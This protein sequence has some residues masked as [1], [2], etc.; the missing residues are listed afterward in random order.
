MHAH[1]VEIIDAIYHRFNMLFAHQRKIARSTKNWQVQ[2][3]RRP[4]DASLILKASISPHSIVLGYMS[5]VQSSLHALLLLIVAKGISRET[6][7]RRALEVEH[8]RNSA[9]CQSKEGEKRT[10][11]L[12]SEAFI[13]LLSEQDGRGTPHRAEECFGCQSRSGLVLISINWNCS[14]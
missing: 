10:G 1:A 2:P 14:Q 3:A 13:H 5:V 12:V 8:V 7:D 4:L 11:P 9:A 6:A